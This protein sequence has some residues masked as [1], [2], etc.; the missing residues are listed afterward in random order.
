MSESA[1]WPEANKWSEA[2]LIAFGRVIRAW[3]NF[4]F[5]LVFCLGHL[6]GID[7]FRARIVW[8]T[9]PN[10][11]NRKTLLKR[12]VATFGDETSVKSFSSYMERAKGL[13]Q[14]RNLVCHAIGW[15]EQENF[16]VFTKDNER[17]DLGFEFLSTTKLSISNVNGIADAIQKLTSD[18]VNWTPSVVVYTAAKI[19]RNS[20]DEA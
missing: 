11:Q 15:A 20:P 2:S 8:A 6:L 7:Q 17:E 10:F 5:G 19:H 18:I 12:L 13:S 1:E 4:E 9:M 14:K 16:V 3:A